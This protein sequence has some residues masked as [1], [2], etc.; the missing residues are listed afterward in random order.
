[1]DA[2]TESRIL[3]NLQT[4]LGRTTLV[5]ATHRVFVA[6]LCQQVLVLHEGQAVQLGNPHELAQVPGPFARL[7][8]LQSLER[9]LVGEPSRQTL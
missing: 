5:L 4:F 3:E 1:V 6:E 8:R 7:K 2:E 9:E